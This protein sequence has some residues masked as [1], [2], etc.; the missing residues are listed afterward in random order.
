MSRF[1]PLRFLRPGRT[2][3]RSTSH[4][5]TRRAVRARDHLERKRNAER[6]RRKRERLRAERTAEPTPL[7]GLLAVTGF[8]VAAVLGITFAGPVGERLLLRPAALE[9]VA[10]QGAHALSPGEIVR[11]TELAAGASIGSIDPGLVATTVA[12]EPWVESARA[13]R[14]P[15]GTLVISVVER[16]AI[17]R[18]RIDDAATVELVDLRGERFAGALAPGGPLPLVSGGGSDPTL[19]DEALEILGE[20]SRHASLAADPRRV[21]LHLPETGLQVAS[22]AESEA[23]DGHATGYVLQIGEEGPRALLGRRLLTE[24]VA[25]LAAVLDSEEPVLARAR[26]IDLRY[27]DRAVL[28]TEPVSG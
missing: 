8:A 19:P 28:R 22:D 2:R 3:G 6:Q 15:N 18:W 13:L 25:R 1:A 10:I 26:W 16:E 23:P 4:D 12:G 24:R 11:E 17:A 14:L 7:R 20:I 27:A 9:R 5:A 21:I